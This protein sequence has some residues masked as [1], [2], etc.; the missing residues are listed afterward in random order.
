MVGMR[1]RDKYGRQRLITSIRRTIG[2]WSFRE[3]I[4]MRALFLHLEAQIT[5]A[6]QYSAH[7]HPGLRRAQ[8]VMRHFPPNVS[9]Q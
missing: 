1:R 3:S 9:E 8:R 7:D 5:A 4:D 6:H 2:Q